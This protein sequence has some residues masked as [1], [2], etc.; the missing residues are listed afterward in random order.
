MLI[1][2]GNCYLDRILS[3]RPAVGDSGGGEVLENFEHPVLFQ[4]VFGSENSRHL[5]ALSPQINAQAAAGPR[6]SGAKKRTTEFFQIGGSKVLQN[7]GRCPG[8]SEPCPP[9]GVLHF[10]ERWIRKKVDIAELLNLRRSGLSHREI[11][12][13]LSIGKT[14][15]VRALK[16]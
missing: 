7:G 4:R 8:T 6:P 15:V 2:L 16:K 9:T 13:R 5:T 10:G 12:A 1:D 14:F 3:A 11:A